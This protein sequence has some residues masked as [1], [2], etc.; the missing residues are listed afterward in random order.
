MLNQTDLNLKGASKMNDRL[1]LE[2]FIVEIANSEL[3][4]P[5]GQNAKR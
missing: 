1:V 2:T 5:P 4:V 3:R